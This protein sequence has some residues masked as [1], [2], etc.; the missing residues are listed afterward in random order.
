MSKKSNEIENMVK[1]LSITHKEAEELYIF[2][3]LT[4]KE[5]QEELNSLIPIEKK[6]KPIK[7]EYS[8]IGKI[9]TMKAKAKT[10]ETKENIKSAFFEWL[11]ACDEIIEPQEF[12]TN[13]FG[14]FDKNG[15]FYSFKLTKHKT[16]QDGY[17][18]N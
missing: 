5:Q 12:K 7:K 6:E 14:F 1:K 2:D 15:N 18:K 4:E 3:R 16:I 11:K 10:D 9:K 8:P 13:Y 17:K